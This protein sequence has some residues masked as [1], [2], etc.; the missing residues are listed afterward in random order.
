[1]QAVTFP[2]SAGNFAFELGKG[3]FYGNNHL[4]E[5]ALYSTALSAARIAAHYAAGT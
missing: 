3:K 5:V 1:M 4:D 2:S